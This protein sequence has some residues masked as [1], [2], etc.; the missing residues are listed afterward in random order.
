MELFCDHG[1]KR[2]FMCGT[3]IEHRRKASPGLKLDNGDI[4]LRIRSK[5]PEWW[6]WSMITPMTVET[7]SI[8]ARVEDVIVV[9]VGED[10]I[11]SIET[12]AMGDNFNMGIVVD[13]HPCYV[14]TCDITVPSFPTDIYF[15]FGD[16]RRIGTY[17]IYV[18]G[19]SVKRARSKMP[20]VKFKAHEPGDIVFATTDIP[21]QTKCFVR[22]RVTT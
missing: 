22:A 12:V 2:T 7:F 17:Q 20:I 19:K 11:P 9:P 6:I 21:L 10:V 18:D 8:I 16:E 15:G 3:C 4:T 13:Q 5:C 14:R 1:I